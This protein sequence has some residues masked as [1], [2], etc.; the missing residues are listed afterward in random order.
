[1]ITLVD[2]RTALDQVAA[3]RPEHADDRV[4]RSLPPRYVEHGKPCCL[5][6]VIL[7]RCGFTVPQLRQLD[8]ESGRGGGGIKFAESHHPLLRRIAPE[9]HPLLDYLQR[10]QDTGREDWATIADRALQRGRFTPDTARQCSLGRD[11]IARQDAGRPFSWN[12]V[13]S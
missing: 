1:M 12:T 3:E 11:H 9:A 6:A 7:H 5:V 10:R 8:T 4:A 2:I 13:P